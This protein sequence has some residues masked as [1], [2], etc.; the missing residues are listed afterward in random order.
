MPVLEWAAA[1]ELGQAVMDDTHREFVAL[2]NGLG[3]A[4]DAELLAR[5]DAFIAHTETHFG[6]E[7]R[8]ME[9]IDFPPL[10]CHRGEHASV[11]EVAREVRSRVAAGE[12]EFARTLATAL[13]EW[14]PL[15]AQT[16]DAVLAEFIRSAGYTPQAA[17]K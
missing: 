17:A 6:E 7:E 10:G 1:Y 13:A 12:P 9:E 2:L 15:H 8:W 14:F 16:M 11:M 5:L 4:P 3:D